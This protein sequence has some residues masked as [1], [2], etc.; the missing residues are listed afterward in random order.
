M[1][2]SNHKNTPTPR[3][4][5]GDVESALVVC[6]IK[7]R[8]DLDQYIIYMENVRS[9]RINVRIDNIEKEMV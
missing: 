7:H 2:L 1:E 3:V 8:L 5:K 6:I 4:F 9:L